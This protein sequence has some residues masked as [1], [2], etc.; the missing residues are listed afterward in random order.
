[1]DKIRFVPLQEELY[2]KSD[3]LLKNLVIKN[4]ERLEDR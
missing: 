2:S 4:V 1:V 3:K